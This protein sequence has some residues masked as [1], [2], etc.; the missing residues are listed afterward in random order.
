[1]KVWEIL[2]GKR[3]KQLEQES[4]RLRQELAAAIKTIDILNRALKRIAEKS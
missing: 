3:I 2:V 1:M 4:E